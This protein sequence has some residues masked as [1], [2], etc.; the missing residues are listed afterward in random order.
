MVDLDQL[1]RDHGGGLVHAGRSR[2]VV[3]VRGVRLDSRQVRRGDLFVA[4]DGQRQNGAAFARE[5]LERGASALLAASRERFEPLA[6]WSAP[7]WIHPRARAVAGEVAAQLCGHPS[8]DM[9]VV[10]ITGTNGKTTSAHLV[11]QLLMHGGHSCGVLGTAGNRLADGRLRAASHT[12]SDASSLQELVLEHRTLGGTA[13]ALEASSHAL[14]QERLAGLEV[15]VAVFTN[16]TRDH[17]DYHGDMSAYLASKRRLFENLTPQGAAVVRGDDPCAPAMIDAARAAGARVVTYS[18]R[19]AADLT[20]R[21]IVFDSKGTR[22]TIQGMGIHWTGVSVPLLGRFNVENVLAAVAA[23]LVSG[24]SPS[25]L[26]EGLASVS[27]APGRLERVPLDAPFDVFVD[28][29]HTPDALENAL[30][31]LRAV[32]D[33]ASAPRRLVVVFGCGGERDRG[34]RAL[35]GQ[36]A[37][38]GAERV[39]L[40]SDNPRSEDPRAIADDVL[41]GVGEAS[42]EVEL[43]RRRAI[44]LAL[45]S[46]RP[47]DLILIAGKGH[48]TTQEIA[49]AK[50]AFDDRVVC[51]EVGR[52]RRAAGGEPWST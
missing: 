22:F 10:A 24:A 30:D 35:M 45:G 27:A 36:A 26:R 51:L 9:L 13:L 7:V 41:R 43:D 6:R 34:K 48:E 29:A 32:R 17:L 50:L 18:T 33:L 21:D 39:I 52:A 14:D 42:I 1:V 15:S 40:T 49:G 11:Q 19:T 38:R 23:V 31:A 44:E 37:V 46:A 5:A 28:Y 20:A 4:L 12:T 25:S 8:R 3:D 16:L 2:A 47:G